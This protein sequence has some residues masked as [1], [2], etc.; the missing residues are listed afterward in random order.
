MRSRRSSQTNATVPHA[1]VLKYI[2]TAI[3]ARETGRS[4]DEADTSGEDLWVAELAMGSPAAVAVA[5]E[6]APLELRHCEWHDESEAS[7]R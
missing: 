5:M 4:D 1:A 7:L 6:R 3:G 2:G